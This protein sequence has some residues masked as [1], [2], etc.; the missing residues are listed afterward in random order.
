PAGG[1]V[2][3]RSGA[4]GVQISNNILAVQGGYALE[5]AADSE[6]GLSSDYNDLYVTGTGKL[7][8][9][10]GRGFTGPAGWAYEVGLDGHSR[11]ADPRSADPAGPDGVLGYSAAPAGPA[12]VID[13]GDAGFSVTG[14]WTARAGAGLGDD[15]RE[16]IG[17]GTSTA[18][19]TFTGLE[20]GR[21]Y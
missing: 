21:W 18:D 4:R 7:G 11:T 9:W 2:R 19:W 17:S 16:S 12:Q 20:A 14:T 8:R 1:G 15:Y 5:G 10:E 6:Q 3:V 13:D